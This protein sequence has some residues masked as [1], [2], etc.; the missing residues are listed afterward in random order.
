MPS[1]ATTDRLSL[2]HAAAAALAAVPVI[3]AV[4]SLP[5][6][7]LYLGALAAAALVGLRWLRPPWMSDLS[8]ML[9]MWVVLPRRAVDAILPDPRARRGDE[10]VS[11]DTPGRIVGQPPERAAPL[12]ALNARAFDEM[13]AAFDQD[14]AALLEARAR[15]SQPLRPLPPW[16]TWG[17]ELVGWLVWL[18]PLVFVAM[19]A[20][21][22]LLAF[23]AAVPLW[24]LGCLV[25]YGLLSATVGLASWLRA[26]VLSTRA[27]WDRVRAI[28]ADAARRGSAS[29]L[30]AQMQ[31]SSR[32]PDTH[33]QGESSA[34]TRDR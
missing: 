18:V 17:L 8:G 7:S 21:M 24:G 30:I 6:V 28:E 19:A 20:D 33:L 13:C 22:P 26:G 23:V 14:N 31:A 12:V 29:A 5:W 2:P 3:A 1:S 25:L 9:S 4:L 15:W 34:I 10:I 16:L 11:A 32:H 27:D